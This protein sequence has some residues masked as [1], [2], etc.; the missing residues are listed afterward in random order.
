MTS[1]ARH[2]EF[3]EHFRFDV[4]QLILRKTP[5]QLA[6]LGADALLFLASSFA[7]YVVVSRVAGASLLGQYSLVFAWL[8]VF[9]AIA[10]FGI[11]EL[12]MRELG[13]FDAD[14]GKYIG[15]GLVVGLAVSFT[16]VP[17]M[18]VVAWVTNYSAEVK[19][20][21][22]IA[23]FGLP[24]AMLSN[25]VRSGFISS[26]RTDL[27][28]LNRVVEFFLVIPVNLVLLIQGYRLTALIVVVVAGR[29]AASILGLWTLHRRVSQ[30]VWWSDVAFL[31]TLI[32]PALTF[33]FGNSL[34][35]FGMHMN[36]IMLSL[37]APVAV[38]G[39]FTAGM[40]MIEGMLLIPVL[41][42]QFY[43][44]QIA[45]SLESNRKA[46]ITSFH[47]PFRLYFALIIP[48]GVGVFLF[49]DFVV[50][51]VFGPAFAETAPVLRLLALFYLVCAADA[52]MSIILRAA[53]LQDEDLKILAVNP[54]VN[55][56]TNLALIPSMG[57]RGVALGLLSGGLCSATLRYRCIVRELGSP[58]WRTLISTLLL[59]N[60]AIGVGIVVLAAR[61]PGWM[62]VSLYCFLALAL[63]MRT[64]W[65]PHG[66][67]PPQ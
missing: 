58:R 24:A 55:L 18:I 13:R 52:Q 51:L 53:G 17:L 31:R 44:P 11:P 20:A 14:R 56:L 25:V 26:R 33:A 64:S 22:T 23:A 19:Q 54:A 2:N 28:L 30:V 10:S 39:Y 36:T 8:L 21:I 45:A 29:T 42:G 50:T 57:G 9:Q 12:M 34:A 59:S 46:G 37:L 62:Q 43:M 1:S 49:S 7:F 6:L 61:L 5:I 27:I 38:V 40:K 60:L 3:T 41:F 16:V 48:A 32:S 65:Q 66:A 67:G 47:Q 35:L 15:A 63:L 4:G